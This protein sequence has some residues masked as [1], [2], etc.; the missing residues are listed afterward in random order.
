MKF[1][2]ATGLVCLLAT[3][4]AVGAS[5]WWS[6]AGK[7]YDSLCIDV[8]IIEAHVIVAVYNRWHETELERWLSDHGKES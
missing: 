8:I 5:S 3:T 2:L 6:K 4:E 1:N 7:L